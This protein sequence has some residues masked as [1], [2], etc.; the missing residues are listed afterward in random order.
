M[1]ENV[2]ARENS[3]SNS[4]N[5]QC[6]QHGND[7]HHYLNKKLFCFKVSQPCMVWK[8]ACDITWALRSPMVWKSKQCKVSF[9]RKVYLM[10]DSW[11]LIHFAKIEPF[12]DDFQGDNAWARNFLRG[13][14]NQWVTTFLIGNCWFLIGLQEVLV[15][16]DLRQQPYCRTLMLRYTACP[17]WAI[18]W[19]M[20]KIHLEYG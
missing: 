12:A 5:T 8:S 16:R 2:S 9:L 6:R 13:S 15:Y 17:Q 1:C 20:S 10:T 18:R 7:D 4:V 14:A 11:T 3:R 19:A